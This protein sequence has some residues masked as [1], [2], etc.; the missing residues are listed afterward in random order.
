MN[1][2]RLLAAAVAAT[3]GDA[4]YGF[5]VYGNL[6][7][8]EFAK[9]PA[10]YRPEDVSAQFLP[11][12]FAGIF[13]AMIALAAIYSKGY[14]GGSG[15]GE[16]IRFGLLVG[17]FAACFFASVSYGTQNMNKKLA[18][19]LACAGFF[20]WTLA[21]TLIGLVYKPAAAPSRRAAGV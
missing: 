20:E 21:G 19:M 9:Y 18:L 2:G 12:M 1:V 13:V 17:V 3:I 5:L 8:P 10:L 7:A 6:M 4:V 11:P 14:E 15:I 16:G